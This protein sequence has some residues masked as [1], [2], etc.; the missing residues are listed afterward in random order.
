MVDQGARTR[1]FEHPGH[2]VAGGQLAGSTG[3]TGRAGSPGHRLSASSAAF[4]RVHYAA[5]L[6]VHFPKAG[7][8]HWGED[9]CRG[10][11]RRG[12]W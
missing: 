2:P 10:I 11:G 1:G 6:A 4:L 12:Y 9:A 7:A 3:D 5:T 8:T